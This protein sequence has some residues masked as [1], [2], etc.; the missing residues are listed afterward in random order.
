MKLTSLTLENFR[1]FEDVAVD[2][3]VDGVIG[4]L[5][6]NG[7]G[8]S[9]LLAAVDWVLF[10]SERGPTALPPH[11][12][13]TD[14]K[15]CRVALEF[16]LGEQ[17]FRVIRSTKS[18]ELRLLDSDTRLANTLTSTTDE[19]A[20]TL[21]MSRETFQSTFYARQREIQALDGRD[22]SRR[23]GQL[24]RLLGIERLR[25]AAE[26]ARTEAREQELLLNAR[27]SD[28]PD[29]KLELSKLREAE[30]AAR[31]GAPA[32]AAATQALAV[33]DTH[34]E[35]ARKALT[36]IHQQA[37]SAQKAEAAA[38][39]AA[40]EAN[41]L[42][43]ESERASI[44][45]AEARQAH[46]RAIAIA[47]L[48]ARTRE[49]TARERELELKRQ[50]SEQAQ[51]LRAR[52]QAAQAGA[53]SLQE[54]LA[55]LPDER[56][57]LE[58]RRRQLA[59]AEKAGKDAGARMIET[60]GRLS[61]LESEEREA[62]R[63]ALAGARR[64]ELAAALA[65][66]PELQ[67]QAQQAARTLTDVQA[68]ILEVERHA[69]EERNNLQEIERDGPAAHCLR[70]RRPYGED[71]QTIL[72][73]IRG[74]LSELS[75]NESALQTSL[76]RA[77]STR[78]A[79]DNHLA[80]LAALARELAAIT[81]TSVL[82]TLQHA[83]EAAGSARS[84]LAAEQEG[85]RQTLARAEQQA[86]VLRDEIEP[87]IARVDAWG[88][89][90]REQQAAARDAELL[91]G[92][93]VAMPAQDYDGEG[94]AEIRRELGEAQAAER[95]LA[96]LISL[97]EQLDVL[98]ARAAQALTA[99]TQATE[100]QQ[101]LVADAQA[102]SIPED[103]VESAEA[104]DLAA[105]QALTAAAQQ[106]HETEQQA[107]REDEAVNTAREAVARARQSARQLRGERVEL[108]IRRRVQELLEEFRL[109]RSEHALP[110]LETDTAALLA[111]VTRGRYTDVH[112]SAEAYA[113]E[114]TEEG[115]SHPLRRFS[116]GEQD[117]TNLCLRLALSRV[118]ARDRG[119]DT[120][121]VIL[122]E[123]LGSQDPD[124]RKALM[125]ELRELTG[126]FQQVFVVSHFTDIV[127]G[128]DI[129]LNVSR[130]DPPAPATVTPG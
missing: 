49:L 128:C 89:V 103:A 28:A 59:E 5:G 101:L 34:R 90:E 62:Q 36:S 110:G 26:R 68:K 86:H 98:E 118:L 119:V 108:T 115:A 106:L 23:R 35:S 65:V 63:A 88:A 100:K 4:V 111:A 24:E 69:A 48:A 61:R 27:A 125:E 117:I 130:P 107:I 55:S 16:L 96:S 60:V 99:L 129:H 95:E 67:S 113:L 32:V 29:P 126:E 87:L 127:D 116:G 85:L 122:D 83:A 7:A 78:T 47:P 37:A 43:K 76:R 102:I 8:K 81:V 92:E 44:A 74:H 40:A 52:W 123:V 58:H 91:A 42:G 121:F 66:Q 17:R 80:E 22:A 112:I 19:V 77:S 56:S 25:H 94:H 71:F 39:L 51:A 120:G 30:D 109:H 46:I 11:R 72:D 3:N 31:A 50:S 104:R 97:A 41:S 105:E 38:T 84:A 6:A 54:S 14:P 9:S 82:D 33:A 93:M 13:G 114:I 2:L 75:A 70:C 45:A 53:T 18:A 79:A 10:G 73:G 124:R 57:E 15:S 1:C 64:D 20:R 12:H 21:G